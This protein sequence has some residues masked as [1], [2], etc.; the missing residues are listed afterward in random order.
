MKSLF[1]SRSFL[2]FFYN[3]EFD[4]LRHCFSLFFFSLFIFIIIILLFF[5]F[6]ILII[7]ILFTFIWNLALSIHISL[8]SSAVHFLRITVSISNASIGICCIV[9]SLVTNWL[10]GKGFTSVLNLKIIFIFFSLLFARSFINRIFLERRKW[11]LFI[12]F[13]LLIILNIIFI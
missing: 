10:T 7:L 6:L 1:F 2:I 5:S 11:W 9:C 12:Y 4:L 13:K 3:F 8:L